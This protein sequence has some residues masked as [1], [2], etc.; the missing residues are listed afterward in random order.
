MKNESTLFKDTLVL[1]NHWHTSIYIE[2]AGLPD[3]NFILLEKILELFLNY[4]TS[5]DDTL[6]G[7][8]FKELEKFKRFRHAIPEAINYQVDKIRKKFNI[9]K[10]S[11]DMAVPDVFL[12][13]VLDLY[14]TDLN[15]SNLESYLFGH[16]GN[17]HIHVNIIPHSIDEYNQ[18]KEMYNNWAKEVI[19]MGGTISA[20]HGIGKIKTLLLREMYGSKFIK[21]MQ[22]VK[23]QFDPYAIF[24]NGNLY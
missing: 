4:D 12:P 3:S 14:N 6:I 20:E 5:D 9:T 19:K 7:I 8:N 11:T 23:K 15:K 17:N 13:K 22:K 10:L 16:I 18:G 21:Q 24:N 2:L 1:K